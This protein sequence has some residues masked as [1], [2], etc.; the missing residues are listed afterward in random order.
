MPSRMSR[1]VSTQSSPPRSGR[2]STSPTAPMPAR[3]GARWPHSSVRAG[4]SGLT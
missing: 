1:E 2:P 4:P 3:P